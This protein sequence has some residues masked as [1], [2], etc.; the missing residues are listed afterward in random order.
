MSACIHISSTWHDMWPTAWWFNRDRVPVQIPK[1]GVN[2]EMQWILKSCV[3]L[4]SKA[5]RVSSARESVH[6]TAK[7]EEQFDST[8]IIKVI[9]T[10][11][12]HGCEVFESNVTCD[13]HSSQQASMHWMD[14]TS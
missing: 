3:P 4:A 7:H 2:L 6:H 11:K 8:A 12:R 1:V 10:L 13:R 14:M 9:E 5:T